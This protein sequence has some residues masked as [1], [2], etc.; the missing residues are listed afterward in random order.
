M[1]VWVYWGPEGN[2]E[3]KRK[4][5]VFGAHPCPKKSAKPQ[6]IAEHVRSSEVMYL[7]KAGGLKNVNR[8][9]RSFVTVSHSKWHVLFEHL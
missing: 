4:R 5:T 8:S 1:A 9:K 6:E 3:R 7:G 2:F